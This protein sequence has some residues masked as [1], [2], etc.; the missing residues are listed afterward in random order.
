M[1]RYAGCRIGDG[2]VQ[3]G[4]EMGSGVLD[5]RVE[6]LKEGYWEEDME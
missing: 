4:L 3:L 1:G 6:A 5:A 2:F